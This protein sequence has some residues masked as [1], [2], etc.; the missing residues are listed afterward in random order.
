MSTTPVTLNSSPSPDNQKKNMLW[1]VM[2]SFFLMWS[3]FYICFVV[4]APSSVQQGD[5]QVGNGVCDRRPADPAKAFIASLVVTIIVMLLLW[6][7][8]AS[9]K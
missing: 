9:M 6:L 2:T 8:V 5:V 3:F 7:V 1:A 4:F